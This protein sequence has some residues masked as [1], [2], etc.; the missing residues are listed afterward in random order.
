MSVSIADA[1]SKITRLVTVEC[2]RDLCLGHFLTFFHKDLSDVVLSATIAMF[3]DDI[4]L[5]L[6]V[7]AT[8]KHNLL[9]YDLK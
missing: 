1:K 3:V 9:Q 6:P 4:K 5:C 7:T 2:H 8:A